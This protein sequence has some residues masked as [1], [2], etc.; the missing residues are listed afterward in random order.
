MIE[1]KS[2]V[3]DAQ[4]TLA[5]LARKV[6]LA[7]RIAPSDWDVRSVS[8]L[9]VIADTRTNRRRI[10]ALEATFSNAFPDR[11]ASIRRLMSRNRPGPGRDEALRVAWV[12]DVMGAPE[13][14]GPRAEGRAPS[15]RAAPLPL[16]HSRIVTVPLRRVPQRACIIR[17]RA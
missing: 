5:A 17:V 2:A 12:I 3:A 14:R 9:L 7:E 6:R 10:A 15:A 4:D 11:V 1:V 16:S 13:R 8:P